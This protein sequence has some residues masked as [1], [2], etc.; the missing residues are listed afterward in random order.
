MLTATILKRASQEDWHHC[1]T[2]GGLIFTTFK[3]L[4]QTLSF[5]LKMQGYSG[6]SGKLLAKT[7]LN[8]YY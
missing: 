4:G 7:V 5:M 2:A 3:D 1:H 6:F 8:Y